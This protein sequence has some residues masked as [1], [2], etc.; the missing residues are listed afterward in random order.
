MEELSKD[1]G[2]NFNECTKV[3]NTMAA[4][5]LLQYAREVDQSKQELLCEA[6]Y[7]ASLSPEFLIELLS[8]CRGE[9]AH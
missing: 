4:H 5:A 1:L 9:Q 6:L 8:I 3:P 2:L 7:K